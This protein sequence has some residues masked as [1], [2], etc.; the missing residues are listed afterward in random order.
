MMYS[1]A[2]SSELTEAELE[3]LGDTE[4]QNPAHR[5]RCIWPVAADIYG[6]LIDA[7]Y[8]YSKYVMLPARRLE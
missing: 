3:H 8:L 1:L 7:V 5:E 6:E 2:G 4:I